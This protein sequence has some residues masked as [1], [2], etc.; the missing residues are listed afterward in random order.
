MTA[1][2][3]KY[4][5]ASNQVFIEAPEQPGVFLGGFQPGVG[6]ALETSNL[7]FYV[8]QMRIRPHGTG[9]A[10][11]DIDWVMSFKEPLLFQDVKQLINIVYDDGKSTG[12]FETG[13]LS[14][15]YRMYLPAVNK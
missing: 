9:S 14:F 7:T 15:D 3:G 1:F 8:D 2:L 12:F 11:L 10:V 4:V 6:Q 13:L 5:A